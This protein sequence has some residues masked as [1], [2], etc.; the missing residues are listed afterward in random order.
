MCIYKEPSC[1][2][3][4]VFICDVGVPYQC[5]SLTPWRGD[6]I[7]FRD[8]VHFL[9]PQVVS[10][11]LY[12]EYFPKVWNILLRKY[13]HLR[14]IFLH[15]PLF[16]SGVTSA[17]QCSSLTPLTRSAITFGDGD[18]L[19]GALTPMPGYMFDVHSYSTL[20]L[21]NLKLSSPTDLDDAE[22]L[23]YRSDLGVGYNVRCAGMCVCVLLARST[24]YDSPTTA[25]S[26]RGLLKIHEWLSRVCEWKLLS[27]IR[28]L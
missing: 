14:T 1:L 7:A 2:L 23:V 11:N 10:Q 25:N 4:V 19:A 20:L 6:D 9:A 15:L 12:F 5:S 16:C 18:A 28:D 27:V 3:Y 24:T 26:A 22:L 17:Y 13:T 8:G 21:M